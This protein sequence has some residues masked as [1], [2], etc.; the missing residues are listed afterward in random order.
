MSLFNENEWQLIWSDHFDN[1]DLDERVWTRE[2]RSPSNNEK[3]YYINDKKCSYTEDSC[4]VIKAI[5]ETYNNYSFKSARINTEDKKWF[6][7][8]R[9]EAKIKM[10]NVDGSWPAFWMIGQSNKNKGWPRCGEIDIM[11]H[12][13]TN[14]SINNA[15]HYNTWSPT[16]FRIV[17]SKALMSGKVDVTQFHIYGLLWSE[18]EL[19][20][21]VDDTVLYTVKITEAMG[22]CFNQPAYILLNMAIGGNFPKKIPKDSDMPLYMFTDWVKVYSNH[23]GNKVRNDWYIDCDNNKYYMDSNG[24]PLKKLQPIGDEGGYY[25]DEI[26]GVMKKGFISYRNMI[27][28]FNSDGKMATGW[29][30]IN[31]NWYYF[32]PYQF[33]ITSNTNYE[34]GQLLVDEKIKNL[35]VDK[36]GIWMP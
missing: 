35:N 7:Y 9:I 22:D 24:E 32:N 20:F 12:I 3:A 27:F 11:E 36:N 17:T 28:Y 5:K 29:T 26:T 30:Y 21:Y 2:N 23:L 31:G 8:G 6:T 18:N 19:K 33:K 13:N 15:V 25:F 10:P 1:E 34:F 16:K 14:T 4:L